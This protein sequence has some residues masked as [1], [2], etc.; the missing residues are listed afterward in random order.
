[1]G[2]ILLVLEVEGQPRRY[3]SAAE[4]VTVGGM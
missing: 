2:S 1:M 3:T 4:S